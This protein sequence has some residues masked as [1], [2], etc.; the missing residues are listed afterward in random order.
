MFYAPLYM[1]IPCGYGVGRDVGYGVDRELYV[2]LHMHFHLKV[3]SNT[4]LALQFLFTEFVLV[5]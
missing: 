2:Q 5:F 3:H 4:H 1:H